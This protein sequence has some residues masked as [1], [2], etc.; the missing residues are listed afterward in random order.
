MKQ[1]IHPFARNWHQKQRGSL[2]AAGVV[3]YRRL[4]AS[5]DIARTFDHMMVATVKS[6]IDAPNASIRSA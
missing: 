4:A 3:V 1:D 5:H 6:V 2:P